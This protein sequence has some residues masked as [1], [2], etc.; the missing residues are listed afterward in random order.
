M[1]ITTIALAVAAM[2]L[3]GCSTIDRPAEAK[4]KEGATITLTAVALD[5]VD[6]AA[7]LMMLPN[8][9]YPPDLRKAG[10]TGSAI[11]SFV[12]EIDG[13]T[14]ELVVKTATHPDFGTAALAALKR[15][16]FRPASVG[17][18]PVRVR[19]EMPL[20]FPMQ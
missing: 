5:N 19:M 1:R 8:P 3:S 15:A 13:R 14:S 6:R 4:P 18:R 20:R 9:E 17:G 7:V 10:V 12:V 11:I 2:V 16:R